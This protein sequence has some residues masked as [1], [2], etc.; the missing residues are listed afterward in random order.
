MIGLD[1]PDYFHVDDEF[2]YKRSEIDTPY[3]WYSEAVRTFMKVGPIYTTDHTLKTDIYEASYP[4]YENGRTKE[5]TC[6]YIGELNEDKV[7]HGFG[8]KIVPLKRI[9]EGYYIDGQR[10]GR[11]KTLFYPF[12]G[13]GEYFKDYLVADYLDDQVHGYFKHFEY[14]F[15]I[16]SEGYTKEDKCGE[17]KG[18]DYFRMFFRR[19]LYG[20]QNQGSEEWY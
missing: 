4:F 1:Y 2:E 3:E 13:S 9:E 20:K 16:K 17:Q 11:W 5:Y 15:Q 18:Y 12:N 7:P 10:H 8:I 6:Y 19:H 14:D